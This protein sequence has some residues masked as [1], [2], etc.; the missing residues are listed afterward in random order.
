MLIEGHTMFRYIIGT[1][2]FVCFMGAMVSILM[3]IYYINVMFA[4]L[5]GAGNIVQNFS[6]ICDSTH[7]LTPGLR[8]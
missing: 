8:I 6:Y 3:S 7:S 2:L 5:A 4:N 1:L